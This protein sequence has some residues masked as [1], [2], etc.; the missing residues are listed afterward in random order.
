MSR[1]FSFWR[2]PWLTA[3][4]GPWTPAHGWE[5]SA[6]EFPWQLGIV[7]RG[8]DGRWRADVRL[9]TS[10]WMDYTLTKTF[11]TR[12]AAAE[13]MLAIMQRHQRLAPERYQN[14][15]DIGSVTGG[16]VAVTLVED[17]LGCEDDTP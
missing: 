3:V 13:R 10:P 11:P 2:G 16:F 7:R 5:T 8:A 9:H 14:T 15:F 12:D 4:D 6:V 17:E 1:R